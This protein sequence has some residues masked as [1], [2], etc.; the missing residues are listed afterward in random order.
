MW[1]FQSQNSFSLV[2]GFGQRWENDNFEK[3]QRR[4]HLHDFTNVGI[5]HQNFGTQRIQL[6]HL[7]RGR[8]KIVEILLAKLFR[9]HG[10][11]HLGCRFS[12]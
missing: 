6:E 8:A 7:G 2:Q 10:R 3:V 4:R 5:Q 11:T 1:T 9:N 12:G